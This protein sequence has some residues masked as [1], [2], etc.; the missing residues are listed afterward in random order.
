MTTVEIIFL[1]VYFTVLCVLASYGS[2]RYRM[3]YLY[4]RH[5]FKLPTPNGVLPR[6][7]RVTIQL[8]IFNEMY[9]VERLID[10]VCRI[11]YPRELLEIQ[12]L[13]DS[14][15]ETCAIARACVE[16]NRQLGHNVVYI[17]RENRHG[18]KAGALE[19]GLKLS[20]G[21][22]VAVFD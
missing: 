17:H 13:D 14:I 22:Y 11:D 3:A 19:H 16:R 5:K 18:F 1:G 7:P 20:H 15:D 12:V 2:H 6:L 4:Y 8:P 9:V 10:S 21:E